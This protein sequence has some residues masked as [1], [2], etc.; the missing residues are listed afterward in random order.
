MTRIRHSGFLGVRMALAACAVAACSTPD[1]PDEGE[2]DQDVVVTNCTPPAPPVPI[3]FDR[4]LVIRSRSVVEDGV[5][6]DSSVH[7]CRTS[8]GAA[9]P[10]SMQGHWT[11]GYMMAAMAGT[12]DP[13]SPTA[14]GFVRDW[15]KRWLSPQQPNPSKTAAASRP[16]IMENLIRPWLNATGCLPTDTLDSCPLDLKK[17]P[18]R[19]LAFVNRIDL[20]AIAGYSNGGEFRVVFGAIGADPINCPGCA[21]TQT[22]QAT[23][24]LEYAL[25][26]TRTLLSWASALHSLSSSNPDDLSQTITYRNNLQGLTDAIVGFNASPSSKSLNRSAIAHVRTNEIAFDCH[27]GSTCDGMTPPDGRLAVWEMRQFKLSGPAGT[28]SGVPLVQDAVSQTPQSSD[29]LTSPINTRLIT[30]RI[31]I[32]NGDPAFESTDNALLG[33]SSLSPSGLNAVVW[34]NVPPPGS[35]ILNPTTAPDLATAG[36]AQ[37]RHQ[38]ALGTCN[39]CHY[40]DTA[41]QLGLFHIYPRDAGTVSSISSFL[42]A[43]VGSNPLAPAALDNLA[44]L[45]K[46]QVPDPAGSGS[47]FYYNEPWRRACEI[48]R[49]LSG[50]TT[51]FTKPSGHLATCVHPTCSTGVAL[52]ASCNSCATQICAVDS[53]CCTTSWDAT[54]VSEVSSVCGKTCP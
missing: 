31:A 33:N 20:P 3:N 23:V 17:A 28:V 18:F 4:E 41:N 47:L 14:K 48:R 50:S 24:I 42:S 2:T 27:S 32:F 46:H 5:V 12:S 51:P 53:F 38:F 43:G 6:G 36:R 16:A 15:L 34:E 22:L 49:I 21:P 25:P 9:C 39:G 13:T 35:P 30:N 7:S 40:A 37:T 45:N 10:A 44:P 26:A 29:N 19:L 52:D 8:W 54:C 11:F 1:L